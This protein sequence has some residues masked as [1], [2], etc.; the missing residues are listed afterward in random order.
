MRFRG[1]ADHRHD[2]FAFASIRQLDN[3]AMQR[4]ALCSRSVVRVELPSLKSHLRSRFS[5]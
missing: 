1:D 5:S 3:E 4:I 2:A